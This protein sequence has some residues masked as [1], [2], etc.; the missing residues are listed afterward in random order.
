VESEGLLK[1]LIINADDLGADVAR[2]EGI[3]EAIEAGVVTAASI[4][5]NGPAF[6]DVLERMA[7]TNCDCISFGIHLNLTEGMPLIPGLKF[8][9][10]PDGCCCGKVEG[11]RRMMKSGDAALEEEIW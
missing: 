4:L 8:I 1:N 5:I 6:Y 10:G 7:S 2:N 9:T 3:F 11:H